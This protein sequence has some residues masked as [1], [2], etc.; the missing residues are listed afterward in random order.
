MNSLSIFGLCLVALQGGSQDAGLTQ[1]PADGQTRAPAAETTI[2]ISDVNDIVL[3]RLPDDPARE[4]LEEKLRRYLRN[5]EDAVKGRRSEEKESPGSAPKTAA[6]VGEDAPLPG[7]AS[8]SPRMIATQDLA[9]CARRYMQPAFEPDQEQ[10]SA[11]G[12]GTLLANLRPEQHKWL[13]NFLDVQRR[14]SGL[15]EISF[16]VFQGPRGVFRDLG[17]ST[18]STVLED[19]ALVTAFRTKTDEHKVDRISAPRIATE[20]GYKA[21]LSVLDQ[22]AYIEDWKLRIVEPGPQEIAEPTINVVQDGFT[23]S[24]RATALGE[25][26]YG[27]D[28]SFISSKLER[29]MQTRK[30]RLSTTNDHLVEIGI[31]VVAKISFE[32]S[33]VLADGA[34]VVFTAASPEPEKDLAILV[35][36]KHRSL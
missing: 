4:Q 18:S 10:M 2:V 24:V 36:M 20:N 34:A 9:E 5:Q 27:L 15:V 23:A 3:K 8:A 29:P 26:T 16:E 1:P 7:K 6:K 30:I 28:L 19:P 33:L 11:P 21:E 12:E 32:S 22:V 31:P 35:T 13:Q 17:L 25:Q 14:A